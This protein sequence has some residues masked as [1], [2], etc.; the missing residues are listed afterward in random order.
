[1]KTNSF[2]SDIVNAFSKEKQAEK[3]AREREIAEENE[4]VERRRAFA[5]SYY[6]PALSM[7]DTWV[8]KFTENSN[9]YYRLKPMHREYLASLLSFVTGSPVEIITG[10]MDELE[11]DQ[12]LRSH[13]EASLR[14][15]SY[16]RDI[17]VEY[18]R[19]LGWYSFVRIQKPKVVIE[20][21]VDHGVGS[22]V[23]ASALLRNREEGFEGRY[24]G[25]E[26]RPE[27]GQLFNG[28]YAEVGEILYGDS[29]ETL[30]KFDKEIDIFINDSDHSVD[31][32]YQEYVTIKDKLS[33][34]SVILGDNSHV[35]DRLLRFSRET[36]RRFIF[37]GEKPAD[38]WYPGCGIG[39]SLPPAG[40]AN[41]S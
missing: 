12:D 6:N 1:M 4:R 22:C 14:D 10:Y 11:N 21:G 3:I 23:L 35:T 19:R 2:L 25:T 13:L 24:Y 16:G 40:Q 8:N 39:I 30:R 7:I 17:Q 32:E 18:G 36:N 9:F 38:H 33:P 28:K 20:T 41:R 34:N 37:W 26:L 31:Y 29:I 15:T 5:M 27:A